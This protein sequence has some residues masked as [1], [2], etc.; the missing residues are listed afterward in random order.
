MPAYRRSDTYSVPPAGLSFITSTTF[1]GASTVSVDGC[2]TSAYDNY[3]IILECSAASAADYLGF[4]M[5]AASTDASTNYQ[6]AMLFS[7]VVGVTSGADSSGN[8]GI[9]NY[10]PI[11]YTNATY[12]AN[13]ILDIVSPAIASRTLLTSSNAN[14]NSNFQWKGGMHTT[15]TAYDGFTLL[16]VTGTITGTAYIYG[17]RK[18]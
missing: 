1:S 3:R 17:Y 15:A 10:Y 13:A 11:G 6:W 18:S 8:T 12:G 14:L 16:P 7:T 4:R 2:F 5:R 9:N